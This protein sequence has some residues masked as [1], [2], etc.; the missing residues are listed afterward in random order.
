MTKRI[1]HRLNKQF[2]ALR[3]VHNDKTLSD[4]EILPT[5]H[6]RFILECYYI[7]ELKKGFGEAV[8]PSVR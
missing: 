7:T 8:K 6:V 2:P 5:V 1:F 3:F 4:L